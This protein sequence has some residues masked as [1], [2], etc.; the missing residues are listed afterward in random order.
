MFLDRSCI[1]TDNVGIAP[2]FKVHDVVGAICGSSL[3]TFFELVRLSS[4]K[5]EAH[6]VPQSV[7]CVEV[8]C[9]RLSGIFP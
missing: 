5:V 4:S 3:P 2:I 7:D 8:R 1:E 9:N 6:E